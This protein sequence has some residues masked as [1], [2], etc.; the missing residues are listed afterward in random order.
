MDD[1]RDE[2]IRALNAQSRRSL[3]FPFHNKKMSTLICYDL[4][5]KK[6]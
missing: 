3:L 4:T 6:L 5:V 1:D 2:M